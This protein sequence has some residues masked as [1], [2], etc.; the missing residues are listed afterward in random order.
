MLFKK[1]VVVCFRLIKA[2][3]IKNVRWIGGIR[4]RSV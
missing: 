4:R 3:I 2:D 1:R